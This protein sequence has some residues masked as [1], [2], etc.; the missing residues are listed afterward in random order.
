MECGYL[1]IW[2]LQF[3]LA[4]Y[5]IEYLPLHYL[6]NKRIARAFVISSLYVCCLYPQLSSE[7]E[8]YDSVEASDSMPAIIWRRSARFAM[9]LIKA[10]LAR[11]YLRVWTG[12]YG[13]WSLPIFVTLIELS[14]TRQEGI[15]CKVQ[16]P[17]SQVKVIIISHNNK[18]DKQTFQIEVRGGVWL[19][20]NLSAQ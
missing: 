19:Y 20:L 12:S 7:L 11:V 8:S 1:W 15:G 9:S 2:I 5:Y 14:H 4:L 10:A 18:W 17:T 13:G 6:E 3:Q 16:G